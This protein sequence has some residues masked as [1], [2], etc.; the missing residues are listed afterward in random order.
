M[1]SASSN[2]R[3]AR[4]NWKWCTNLSGKRGWVPEAGLY[5]QWDTGHFRCDG[6][7]LELGIL[8]CDGLERA[9]RMPTGREE[10]ERESVTAWVRSGAAC[11][12]MGSKLV[13]PQVVK[14]GAC[15]SITTNLS[16]VLEWIRE[17]RAGIYTS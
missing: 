2:K 7:A 9:R 17:A 1:G 6:Y 12:G 8:S 16:L 4:S 3:G 10:P 15:Q 14:P 5:R 13:S 11:L